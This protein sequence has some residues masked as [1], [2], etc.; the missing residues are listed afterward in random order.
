MNDS[1]IRR[2]LSPILTLREGEAATAVMMFIYS[3]LV[4]TAYN[5]IKPSA[6]GKFI[7][8]VGADNLPWVML[9]SQAHS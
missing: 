5:N 1:F 3:F 4:M 9:M 6:T 2:L 8:D 7:A